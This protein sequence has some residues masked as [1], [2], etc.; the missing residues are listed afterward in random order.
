MIFL[1][2]ETVRINL[3]LSK[4]VQLRT[5]IGRARNRSYTATTP[6]SVGNEEEDDGSI[7]SFILSPDSTE[8]DT[9]IQLPSSEVA[10]V[11]DVTGPEDNNDNKEIIN[12]SEKEVA[13]FVADDWI[14]MLANKSMSMEGP[15]E[16]EEILFRF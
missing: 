5:T 15:D 14:N 10:E 7:S 9:L 13:Y 3:I 12:V 2:P 6:G 16:L 1:V 4:R 11:I 8:S